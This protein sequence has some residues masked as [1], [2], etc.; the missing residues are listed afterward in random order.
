VSFDDPIAD[1]L[2]S[3]SLYDR[4][5][6]RQLSYFAQ[7]IDRKLTWQSYLLFAL[8]ALLPVLWFLPSGVREAY[9]PTV[10]SSSPKLTFVALV[11]VVFVSATGVGHAFVEYVRVRFYPLDE[12]QARDLVAFEGL[13][14]MLGF[15][16]G[17]LAAFSTY[18]LV[19][20]GFGGRDLIEAFLAAGGGN[21]FAPSAL[22]ITVGLVAVVALLS[23]VGLQLLSAYLHVRAVRFDR[24]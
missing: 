12:R 3:D 2:L 9:L 14:S 24:A 8:A 10:A 19:L 11:A 15:G 16:T 17:G 1:M 20:L 7:P 6:A 4:L 22:N 21:P 23:A 13:C 18:A 5:R